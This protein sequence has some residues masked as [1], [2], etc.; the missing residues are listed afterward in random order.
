MY[1]SIS[2]KASE[3][4]NNIPIDL[5]PTPIISN[6][7][8]RRS[9]I[10]DNVVKG[11]FPNLNYR[12]ISLITDGV[13]IVI[14]FL[15]IKQNGLND[16]QSFW[17][18]LIANDSLDLRAIIEC[19]LPFIDDPTG[20]KRSNLTYLRD[21]Y[22]AEEKYPNSDIAP[23]FIYCNR[24]YDHCFRFLDTETNS[25]KIAYRPYTEKIFKQ[26]LSMFL[27]TIDQSSNKFHVNWKTI[28]PIGIDEYRETELYE[29]TINKIFNS[30]KCFFYERFVDITNGISFNDIYNVLRLMLYENVKRVKWLI[31]DLIINPIQNNIVCIANILLRRLPLNLIV[32]GLK[33]SEISSIER[34]LFLKNWN[35]IISNN[36]SENQLYFEET[37]NESSKNNGII[38]HYIYLFLYNYYSKTELLINRGFLKED[39]QLIFDNE[40]INS[41][42]LTSKNKTSKS[43]IKISEGNINRARKELSKIPIDFIYDFLYQEID[44]FKGTWYFHVTIGNTLNNNSNDNEPINILNILSKESKQYQNLINSNVIDESESIIITPKN[45]YNYAK[46]FSIVLR[47]NPKTN[48]DDVFKLPLHWCSIFGK[49][50]NVAIARILD[51]EQY[52]RNNQGTVNWYNNRKYFSTFGKGLKFIPE[53]ISGLKSNNPNIVNYIHQKYHLSIRALLPD[54]IFQC[55]IF[56]GYLTRYLPK[57]DVRLINYES[58]MNNSFHYARNATRYSSLFSSKGIPYYEWIKTAAWTD[59]Y[60]VNWI[61]QINIFH[62]FINC[63]VILFTGGTGVGKSLL[64]P[65]LMMYAKCMLEFAM[66]AR[67]VCTEPRTIPTINNAKA[68]G[69]NIGLPLFEDINNE[70]LETNNFVIQ[71]KYR[72]NSHISDDQKKFVRFVTDGSLYEEISD[73]VTLTQVVYEN[74]TV[75]FI[76]NSNNDFD[77]MNE[78]SVKVSHNNKSPVFL[79]KNIYDIV[80]ID[81]SHEHNI[82]MDLILTLMRDITNINNSIKTMIISATMASDEI[83]YRRD[84]RD[85]ND[86][87]AYPLSQFIRDH[88]D[89]ACIDRRVHISKPGQKTRFPI[90]IVELTPFE[91]SEMDNIGNLNFAINKTIEVIEKSH[92]NENA[93]LFLPGT[94]DI[95]IAV[96]ILNERLPQ[97]IIALPLYKDMNDDAKDFVTNAYTRIHEYTGSKEDFLYLFENE[98]LRNQKQTKGIV[99]KGTY[100]RFVIVGTNIAEASVTIPGLSQ[101]F[102][103]G[104]EKRDKY[105]PSTETSTM[106]LDYISKS[107]EEQREGRVGRVGPGTVFKMFDTKLTENI[108]TRAKITEVD[109]EDN[110]VSLLVSD[111]FERPIIDSCP[112]VFKLLPHPKT[113][114]ETWRDNKGKEHKLVNWNIIGG[115]NNIN[116]IVQFNVLN[117]YNSYYESAFPM[118][119]L[120][121]SLFGDVRSYEN[122]IAS[123]YQNS[124]SLNFLNFYYNYYGI[125]KTTNV[126]IN[127]VKTEILDIPNSIEQIDVDENLN[128]YYYQE[129]LLRAGIR[130]RG[131]LLTFTSRCLSGYPSIDLIDPDYCFYMIHPDEHIVIRNQLSGE[132][133]GFKNDKSLSPSYFRKIFEINNIDTN[134]PRIHYSLDTKIVENVYESFDYVIYPNFSSPKMTSLMRS[135][136]SKFLVNISNVQVISSI[137]D[138]IINKEIRKHII[139]SNNC[140]IQTINEKWIKSSFYNGLENIRKVSLTESFEDITDIIWISYSIAYDA[141]LIVISLISL[142]NIAPSL[143][144]LIDK[145]NIDSFYELHSKE[146]RGDDLYLYYSIIVEI[147]KALY[148]SSSISKIN[149]ND[150]N[151]EFESQKKT[152]SNNEIIQK[153]IKTGKLYTSDEFY[154]YIQYLSID[155]LTVLSNKKLIARIKNIAKVNFVDEN[156]L[157]KTI[158][159]ILN[160]LLTL[161]KYEWMQ[162]YEKKM[163]INSTS[164]TFE[165]IYEFVK[166]L[167]FQRLFN[168]NTYHTNPNRSNIII[169][170]YEIV[171][172]TFLRTFSRNLLKTSNSLERTNLLKIGITYPVLFNIPSW[173]DLDKNIYKNTLFSMEDSNFVCYKKISISRN[174]IVEPTILVPINKISWIFQLNPFHYSREFSKVISMKKEILTEKNYLLK[175]EKAKLTSKQIANGIR[176]GMS[177]YGINPYGTIITNRENILKAW[178]EIYNTVKNLLPLIKREYLINYSDI[179]SEP[180]LRLTMISLLK[181]LNKALMNNNNY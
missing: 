114:I 96:G 162:N 9:F 33:W 179:Y 6:I 12:D 34:D 120:Q 153:M 161:E 73:T 146:K 133:I 41:K 173:R 83:T 123:N 126:L 124:S 121:Y 76:E 176:Q 28:F 38:L 139:N 3:F 91:I 56:S 82:N 57:A 131:S 136:G 25:T 69:N 30:S 99:T 174:E 168:A 175:L 118:E 74:S 17:I 8:N 87:R 86:N 55:L 7:D 21:I 66:E 48:K 166:K 149:V 72:G 50:K 4:Y 18:S 42:R 43:L 1:N 36:L 39:N 116:S 89:R 95:T 80:I 163:G 111:P 65:L 155:Q 59:F 23:K 135:A 137:S 112:T 115:G 160:S 101:V 77:S 105:D 47:N 88:F 159:Q 113:V 44:H 132:V 58:L 29:Q 93:L 26:N 158:V 144:A 127:G 122:L 119:N 81:E 152:N 78:H 128:D 148:E 15:A 63:R 164:K 177:G 20:I 32:N 24:Q 150:F 35:N 92:N 147:I 10:R 134:D 129:Q 167:K 37:I 100:K 13:C 62:K 181:D 107:S 5:L 125:F 165:N 108:G 71:F 140:P 110:I 45:I 79:S 60:A 51:I 70:E 97:S 31:Y 170:D 16:P 169:P 145:S 117:Y 151:R 154:S 103:T 138:N 19:L 98:E 172:E 104:L 64:G 142:M 102:D 46:S 171:L 22:L 84:F 49:Y 2:E 75:T 54:I 67:I 141:K 52:T 85:I 156:V 178:I 14:N 40:I 130:K 94:R 90:T 157:Q 68:V 109:I 180:F 106:V 143:Q 53:I 61:S 11:I 27:M